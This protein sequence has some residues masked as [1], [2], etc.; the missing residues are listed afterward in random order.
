MTSNLE[1]NKLLDFSKVKMQKKFAH[2]YSGENKYRL[3][4]Q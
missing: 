3:D 4:I 2:M 1:L